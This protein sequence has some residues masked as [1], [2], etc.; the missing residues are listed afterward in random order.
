MNRNRLL[1]IGVVALALAGFVTALFWK[2]S[3]Q[4]TYQPT[5]VPVVVAGAD[6]GVGTKLQATHLRIQQV[7]AATVPTGAYGS[8]TEVVGRGVVVPMVKNEMVLTNKVANESLGAGLSPRIP[9]GMRALAVRVND[10]TSVA[11]FVKAGTRVDI[12]LTGNPSASGS[13]EPLTTTVLE[14][15]EVLT[16]NQELQDSG[17]PKPDTSVVTL[18]V[19]PEQ[20]QKLTLAS[21]QGKIQLSLRNPLDSEVKEVPSTRELSL[22]RGGAPRPVARRVVMAK[23]SAPAPVPSAVIVELIKGDKREESRF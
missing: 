22:Y 14:N 11:G 1:V 17:K 8:I 13:N 16:A 15:V 7:P 2:F 10:V 23:K 4:M 6:L 21:N 9:A 20:A 18:L 12:L 5:T 19:D 3:R